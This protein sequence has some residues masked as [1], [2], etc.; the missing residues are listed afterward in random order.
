[1]DDIKKYTVEDIEK[2]Q[3]KL[4]KLIDKSIEILCQ[5]HNEGN[6][7]KF[8]TNDIKSEIEKPANK[9]EEYLCKKFFGTY[10]PDSS[11]IAWKYYAKT[12]TNL[13]I[14]KNSPKCLWCENERYYITFS[15]QQKFE[16]NL[17][18]TGYDLKPGKNI[19]IGGDCCF[20][21]NADKREKFLKILKQDK[22]DKL[23]KAIAEILNLCLLMHHSPFNFALI[24]KNGG[25]NNIK[26]DGAY[27]GMDRFDLFISTLNLYYKIKNDNPCAIKLIA[28]FE[29]SYNSLV[30]FL[31]SIDTF[32]NYCKLFYP[33]LLSV[34]AEE[35]NLLNRLKELGK[36]S[37]NS[38]ERIVQYIELA[39]DFWEAKAKYYEKQNPLQ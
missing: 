5:L 7:E 9:Y 14:K 21:F 35:K 26:G 15:Y 2:L 8:K 1:M 3:G 28:E 20:N 33:E 6:K 36:K 38:T 31:K 16:N 30:P 17:I 12:H 18:P 34:F 37:I 39:I 32:K 24:P 23:D 13:N 27:Y 11:P 19:G 10:D 29:G 22:N 25:M 4:S